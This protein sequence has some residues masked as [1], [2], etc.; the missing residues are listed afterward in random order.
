MSIF[1][2][3][4]NNVFSWYS[5]IPSHYPD[6][7]TPLPHDC[8]RRHPF[9]QIRQLTHISANMLIGVLDNVGWEGEDDLEEEGGGGVL[10]LARW[11]IWVALF[12]AFNFVLLIFYSS[13]IFR[14][15]T[16]NLHWDSTDAVTHIPAE[17]SGFILLPSS[18][19]SIFGIIN[20]IPF[21]ISITSAFISWMGGVLLYWTVSSA[22]ARIR[23]F[24]HD[25]PFALNITIGSVVIVDS[26][27][28][29]SI[30]ALA[31]SSI[32][33]DFPPMLFGLPIYIL[34]RLCRDQVGQGAGA[35][36][37]LRHQQ[38]KRLIFVEMNFTYSQE[39]N[40]CGQE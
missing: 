4:Q 19:P 35:L 36:F 21:L 18:S 29:D 16:I 14:F 37:V 6:P 38:W 10:D 40:L 30:E 32:S 39:Q 1:R 33:Y 17:E 12:R 31:I 25:L 28:T 26:T 34:G 9:I 8:R 23:R 2:L 11:F 5:C 20:I 13:F 7:I 15:W 3:S 27:A 24:L 22:A